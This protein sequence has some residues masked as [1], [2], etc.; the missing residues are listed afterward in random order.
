[1]PLSAQCAPSQSAVYVSH[2]E[3]DAVIESRDA[4]PVSTATATAV[5]MA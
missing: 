1:V 5:C 2:S 3:S 4:V